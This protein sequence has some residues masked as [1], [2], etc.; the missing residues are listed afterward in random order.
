MT[1][2]VPSP[3]KIE[4][5]LHGTG[6]LVDVTAHV[7]QNEGITH[8]WGRTDWT[9][10]E[11]TPGSLRFS[12][13]NMDGRFTPGNT[14]VYDPGCVVGTLVQW[15]CGT[16]V[17]RFRMDAPALSFP[18]G[19]SGLS[20]VI[21]E[22]FDALQL[23]A[24]KKMR[25]ILDEHIL[26]RSP[27]AYWTFEE[28]SSP[29]LDRSGNGEASLVPWGPDGGQHLHW[30]SQKGPDQDGRSALGMYDDYDSPPA[31]LW[32]GLD[33]AST[34]LST[35]WDWTNT[36]TAGTGY[37]V[38]GVSMWVNIHNV[39]GAANY[40]A[41]ANTGP[42]VHLITVGSTEIYW[43]VPHRGIT[44][45]DGTASGSSTSR[46]STTGGSGNP[47][48]PGVTLN[49]QFVIVRKKTASYVNDVQAYL[50]GTAIGSAMNLGTAAATT[51]PGLV[52]L[53]GNNRT[54]S[55]GGT[56]ID[57]YSGTLANVSIHRPPG[58]L[59][60]S[61]RTFLTPTDIY[62]AG[63]G[64][65]E[66][67]SARFT[68]LGAVLGNSAVHFAAQGTPKSFLLSP[69]HTAGQS[70]L[71]AMCEALRGEDAGMD[72]IVTG[73]VETVRAWLYG[74]QHAL[75]PVVTVDVDEDCIGV[76]E[77]TFDSSGVAV[78]VTV[79]NRHNDTTVVWR[80]STA[81]ARW[82]GTSADVNCVLSSTVD[83]MEVAQYR[84]LLGQITQVTPQTVVVDVATS[85]N[86][87][88][89]A[90]LAL[91]PWVTV[92][93]E[94]FPDAIVGYGSVHC[95]L[96]GVTERHALGSSTF[97]LS[98]L[99]TLLISNDTTTDPG[100][101]PDPEGPWRVSDFTAASYVFCG[102]AQSTINTTDTTIYMYTLRQYDPNQ[103]FLT[104]A[105]TDYP[106]DIQIDNEI[107]HCP[108]PAST[109]ALASGTLWWQGLTGVTRGYAGTT[110]STHSYGAQDLAIVNRPEPDGFHEDPYIMR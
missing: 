33:T 71:T 5:D 43:D 55:I 107:I 49:L 88:T 62:P 45:H 36:G 78:D 63:M 87:V 103:P 108:N 24:R 105:S 82:K 100:G 2:Y 99:P 48:N 4:I 64:V 12:L 74:S 3:Q 93:V 86:N 31:Y 70:M 56:V 26:S 84:A 8:K 98:L 44:C 32:L 54:G 75:T 79:A 58:V 73:G 18:T 95:Y 7:D 28:S 104:T 101:S 21:V 35:S 52:R 46:V 34:G 42:L 39:F 89:A 13:E 11:P 61:T 6:T 27:V 50:N 41:A 38:I 110:A 76:P 66:T 68:R 83:M 109:A 51:L 53:G 65:S 22:A 85:K 14:D 81:D 30:A 102:N 37:D 23:L 69:Q 10:A 80:N 106:L 20:Y 90:M 67:A 92:A 59:Y 25:S 29:A 97:A 16:R 9:S 91:R 60:G 77:L 57:G 72:T 19:V 1:G 96:S 17:R 47:I 94:G 15:T 40:G